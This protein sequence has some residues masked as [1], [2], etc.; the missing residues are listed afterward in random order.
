L[1]Y[2]SHTVGLV[3]PFHT[4]KLLLDL[5]F[6]IVRIFLFAFCDIK[7]RISPLIACIATRIILIVDVMF[8]RKDMLHVLNKLK[9]KAENGHNEAVSAFNFSC[10]GQ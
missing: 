8:I 5:A 7:I 10:F 9:S 6:G 4:V 1:Y 2:G 3:L